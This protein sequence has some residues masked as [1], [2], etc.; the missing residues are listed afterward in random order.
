MLTINPSTAPLS[1]PSSRTIRPGCF[2]LEWGLRSR[3]FLRIHISAANVRGCVNKMH[4]QDNSTTIQD[5]AP[6][7]QGKAPRDA[8]TAPLWLS[9]PLPWPRARHPCST[10][11]HPSSS[12]RDGLEPALA[13]LYPS[14]A[15]IPQLTDSNSTCNRQTRTL[16][17]RPPRR[18]L[19]HSVEN[20][21][22]HR[23]VDSFR[24]GV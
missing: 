12:A 21:P 19:E 14:I 17:S 23:P 16:S 20:R 11:V 9:R 24:S 4:P 22:A 18:R 5:A 1:P 2:L 13:Q 8:A 6:G 15:A 10:G 3:L 7:P